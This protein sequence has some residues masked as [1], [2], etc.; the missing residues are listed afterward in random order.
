MQVSEASLQDLQAG[1]HAAGQ[2]HARQR[3]GFGTLWRTAVV[4]GMCQS[5]WSRGG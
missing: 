2:A 5:I 1:T 3:L 4:K